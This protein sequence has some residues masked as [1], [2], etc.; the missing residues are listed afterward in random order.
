MDIIHAIAIIGFVI[1]FLLKKSEKCPPKLYLFVN[2][3]IILFCLP[4][5]SLLKIPTLEFNGQMIHLVITAWLIFFA[6]IPFFYLLSKLFNWKK[7]TLVCLIVVCGLGNTAFIGLPVIDNLFGEKA[8][9]YAVFI[10]QPGSFLIISTVGTALCIIAA[11]GKISI[12]QILFKLIT[13]P[14]FIAFLFAVFI[15]IHPS[16]LLKEIMLFLIKIIGPLALFSLGLQFSLNFK[17]MEWIPLTFGLFYRLLLGP[18]IVLIYLKVFYGKSDLI[19]TVG[20]IENAMAPMMTAA[21]ISAKYNLNPKLG[22]ALVTLGVPISILTI[23]LWKL[24]LV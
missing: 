11:S 13:F 21:I 5:I 17:E 12:S 9:T 7:E 23:L 18:F 15:P 2:Q 10:D 16:G 4:S 22:N 6:G 20:I 14:P 3:F 19:N 1:G 24:I 8:L